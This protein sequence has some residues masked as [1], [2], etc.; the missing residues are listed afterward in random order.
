L[1]DYLYIESRLGFSEIRAKLLDDCYTPVGRELAQSAFFTDD[2]Q[3][4]EKSLRLTAEMKYINEFLGGVPALAFDDFRQELQY[5]KT[6]G[7]V[8][9]I[10]VLQSIA[11]IIEK[12]LDLRA[13]FSRNEDKTPLLKEWI[14]SIVFD[15]SLATRIGNVLDENGE[16]R[17]NASERLAEIRNEITGQ[18]KKIERTIQSMLKSL[19]EKG[20]VDE[21]V[22]L[23]IRG[24]RLVIP[25]NASKK[26]M[27]KGVVLDESATGQ[28]VFIEPIEIFEMNNE[29]QDLEFG[30][31]REITKILTGLA[32]R[33]RPQIPELLEHIGFLGHIDFING[34]AKLAVSQNAIMPVISTE[35]RITIMQGRHPVL[36]ESLKKSGRKIVPLDLELGPEQ[37][38]I[39]ISG[40]NAGGKSV[41]MKTTGLLQYMFQCGFLIPAAEG[42]TLFPFCDIFADIGD[43]QS[44]EN[45]L[46]TY[47]SHLLNMKMFMERGNN[48]SL[49]LID[50]FGSGTEPESGGA[51]AESVL[52]ILN[53]HG[54]YGVITT[55]YFNLKMFASNHDGVINGAMLF[56][57]ELLK[58]LYKLKTGKPGSSF[59]IEIASSIGLPED[60]MTN[61]SARI[62]KGRIEMEKMIQDLENEKL[63]LEDRRRELEVA[64]DFV[65]ELIEKY[66]KLNK[67]IVENRDRI[68]S[69]AESEA[70]NLLAESNALIE[71]TIRDIKQ[72]QAANDKVKAIRTEFEKKAASLKK[73]K[74]N[75]IEPLPLTKTNQADDVPKK[76][77]VVGNFVRLDD[78]SE[79]GIITEIKNKKV[80]V[81][82]E[83]ASLTVDAARLSAVAV[84]KQKQNNS[85]KK[86][87]IISEKKEAVY[88]LDFRGKNVIEAITELDKF[89]DEAL[90]TGVRSFSILHGKGFGI[91]RKEIR[92]HL[93]QYKD[94][95][96]FDDAPLQFGGEGITLVKFL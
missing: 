90:L 59:A 81:Q 25:V 14:S 19:K 24:G 38:M 41:A 63:K 61:A 33:I 94:M 80:K 4:I 32:D 85:R 44:I 76:P 6:S 77:L 71:K 1:K 27:I 54:V 35:R 26:R 18:R 83:L 78:G 31:K 50:E 65:S 23:S 15:G 58:P 28:T 74:E 67:S 7:T 93:R 8:V 16:I 64:E 21:D 43:Q 91:L 37:R 70:K 34:K 2:S 88:Q 84:Q 22:N 5:L 89:L 57:N 47:S 82:F 11:F 75:P 12:L 40:P 13:L 95:L 42:T 86:V 72:E 46:S 79:T 92:N 87:N 17:S 48:N 96:E 68:I 36:E 52:E 60:V 3:A 56:D 29:V 45:D 9:E 66:N 53:A 49:V 73:A 10:P 30:E 39:I 51:I 69:K 62:G 55:H 20:Q